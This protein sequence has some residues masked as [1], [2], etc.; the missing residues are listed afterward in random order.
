[1]SESKTLREELAEA[2]RDLKDNEVAEAV[3]ELRAEVEK[4]RAE[5]EAHHCATACCGHH[6]NWGHCG[7][8]A[9]HNV[10]IGAAQP[11]PYVWYG[12]VT[13][14][15]TGN[16]SGGYAVTNVAS[17]CNPATTTLSISN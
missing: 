17:G 10:T 13:V 2:V 4:L 16:W 12:T 9:F 11:L 7:C 3:R 1:M 6:C 5:R 14:G 15:N 8:R